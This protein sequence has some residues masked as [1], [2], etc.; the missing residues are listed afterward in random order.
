MVVFHLRE[1]KIKPAGINKLCLSK[2]LFNPVKRKNVVYWQYVKNPTHNREL[3]DKK[4]GSRL[5][6]SLK[7]VRRFY[8]YEVIN[9]KEIIGKY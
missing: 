7:L 5:N 3:C 2:A 9:R 6:H 8:Y 4:Y 1:S